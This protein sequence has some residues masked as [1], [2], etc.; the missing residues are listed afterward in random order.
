M[1]MK[2]SLASSTWGEEEKQAIHD[3]LNSGIYTMG[4]KV[5]KF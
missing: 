1:K 3:T 4:K 2:Y 5:Y